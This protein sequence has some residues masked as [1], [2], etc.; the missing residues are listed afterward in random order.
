MGDRLTV[1]LMPKIR[2][3]ESKVGA[4]MWLDAHPGV[5]GRPVLLRAILDY[6]GKT[7]RE[8]WA[9]QTHDGYVTVD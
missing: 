5:E 4:V 7:V 2:R 3:W 6:N 8:V 9:I 1:E